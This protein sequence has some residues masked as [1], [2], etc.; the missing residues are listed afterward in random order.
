[1]CGDALASFG[2]ANIGGSQCV[3]IFATVLS[4]I[5]EVIKYNVI[6]VLVEMIV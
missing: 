6:K 1:M 3:P 5:L 2:S 4:V